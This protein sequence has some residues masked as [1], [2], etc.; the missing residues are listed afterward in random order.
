VLLRQ[1]LKRL[2]EVEQLLKTGIRNKAI[3]VQ[4]DALLV[5][6]AAQGVASTR[7]VHENAAHELRSERKKV[8]SVVPVDALDI[9][10]TEI[11][12]VNEPCRVERVV[13]PFAG[14]S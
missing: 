3:L 11:R 14:Q 8:R 12:L 13:V 6:S 2:V 7:V 1:S 10:E 9:H 5:T 4:I